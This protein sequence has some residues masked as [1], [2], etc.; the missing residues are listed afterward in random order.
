MLRDLFSRSCQLVLIKGKKLAWVFIELCLFEALFFCAALHSHEYRYQLSLCGVFQNEAPYLKEWID[1]HKLV[2]VEHFYL[3]NNSSTDNYLEILDPYLK[4]GEVELIPWDISHKNVAEFNRLILCDAY[5]DANQRS[6]GETKWLIMIDTDEFIFPVEKDSLTEFL[7]DY[8]EYGSL[9]VNWQM[10][11]TS[12]IPFLLPGES[13]L[14]K[15]TYKAVKDFSSN[16]YTKC[17][18]QPKCVYEINNPHYPELEPKCVSVNEERKIMRGGQ[19]PYVSV[20]KIRIN[21]YWT[22]DEYFFLNNKIPRRKAW[23]GNAEIWL[24]HASHMNEEFC[25]LIIRRHLVRKQLAEEV[26]NEKIFDIRGA[27]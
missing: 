26:H 2:G 1:F 20:N 23:P 3:Y 5:Q 13:M 27:E 18:V 21:H 11:G 24:E 7:E 19:T 9:C 4:S 10:F 17:I 12:N 16:T 8:D 14:E 22:R 6:R 15:L 25:D